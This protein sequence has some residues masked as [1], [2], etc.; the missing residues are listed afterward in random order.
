MLGQLGCFKKSNLEVFTSLGGLLSKYD[1]STA[2]IVWEKSSAEEKLSVLQKANFILRSLMGR[3]YAREIQTDLE[4]LEVILI[5][6]ISCGFNN[7]K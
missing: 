7:L 1:S 4:M 6:S 3:E 5:Y 2:E